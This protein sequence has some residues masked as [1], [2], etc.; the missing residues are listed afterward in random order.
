MNPNDLF[1]AYLDGEL[2]DEEFQRLEGWIASDKS[3][4]AQFMEWMA[5]QSL[6][7]EAIKSNL[8][9]QVLREPMPRGGTRP[10]AFTP[11]W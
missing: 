10:R 1:N 2:S 8:L 4:A 9:E 3:N 11:N 6:T 5:L 7:R